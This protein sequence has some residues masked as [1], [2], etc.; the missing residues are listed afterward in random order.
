MAAKGT[1]RRPIW[2]YVISD[3]FALLFAYFLTL[4]IRFHSGWGEDLFAHIN[5]FLG[6]RDSG[7]VGDD[8]ALF[9][10]LNAPRII[11]LLSVVLIFLYAFT[12]LYEG[13]RFIRRQYVGR[14]IAAANGIALLIFYGYFYLTHNQFHPRSLF[15]T[16]LLLNALL[17]ILF[18]Q[19]VQRLH[20]LHARECAAILVGATPEAEFLEQF[21]TVRAPHGIRIRERLA[22]TPDLSLDALRQQLGDAVLR[23][24]AELVICADKR[25]SVSQ[26][27]EFLGICHDLQVEAKVLSEQMNVLVNEGRIPADFFFEAP[28]I[29]FARRPPEK[30]LPIRRWGGRLLAAL[31]LIVLAPLL[32]VV[33]LVIRWTSPGPALFMQERIGLNRKPFRMYKF[34]TMYSGAD[35]MHAEIEEFNESGD[36]LFK[37]RQDPR[38]TPVGRLLRRLSLDELPQLINVVRGDMTIVGPR[39]LPQRDFANYFEAWHYSRHDALPGL[40]CLWQVSGRSDVSFQNMCI[41]DVYYL[42]TASLMLDL[43]IL[44]RTLGVVLFAKGAY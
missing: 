26:I 42:H 19:G 32:F 38:V 3:L 8:L 12:D 37:I 44:L 25:L 15:A 24:G 35:Q 39:P 34:R 17:C 30:G 29:H 16:M 6:V 13:W 40:T 41:L 18:R 1:V 28:L 27:M 22:W 7:A 11:A 36:V 33:A 10:A 23:H 9:Y 43:K 31:T 4:L 5:I 14:S 2:L 20:R 21:V